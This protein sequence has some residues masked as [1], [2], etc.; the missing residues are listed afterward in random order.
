M[1]WQILPARDDQ[2]L[3]L[4]ADGTLVAWTMNGLGSTNYFMGPNVIAIAAASTYSLAL[5]TEE[6]PAPTELVNPIFTADNFNVS[7]S[8]ARG[9]SYRLE[10]IN[11]LNPDSW[12]LLPPVPGDGT[13]RLLVDPA[14]IPDRNV[15]IG[16]G[17]SRNLP[18]W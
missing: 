8:T 1:P 15:S 10:F 3:A 13:V 7:V 17:S 9:T 4:Q 5:A 6:L 16:C 2:N 18:P 11:A 12:T 14:V